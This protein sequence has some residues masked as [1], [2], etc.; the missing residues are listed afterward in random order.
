MFE[1]QGDQEIGALVRRAPCGDRS[2]VAFGDSAANRKS[3]ACSFV[4]L[5][6]VKALKNRENPVQILFFESDPVVGDGQRCRIR[7]RLS[8]TCERP[9]GMSLR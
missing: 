7:L 1:R 6:S 8:P 5:P 9:G 2:A 3:D 4:F